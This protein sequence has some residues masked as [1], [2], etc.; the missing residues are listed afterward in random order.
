MNQQNQFA[1]IPDALQVV[2]GVPV[3][4]SGVSSQAIAAGLSGLGAAALISA[5]FGIDKSVQG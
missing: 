1:R 3:L 5:K 4:G 2:E